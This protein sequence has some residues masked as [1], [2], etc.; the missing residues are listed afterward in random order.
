VILSYGNASDFDSTKE[1]YEWQVRHN[2]E[3]VQSEGL[4]SG[5]RLWYLDRLLWRQYGRFS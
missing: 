2:L 5:P 3:P 4:L 1:R